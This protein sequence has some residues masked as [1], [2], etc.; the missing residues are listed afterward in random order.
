M[1]EVVQHCPLCGGAEHA[2][3]DQREFKGAVVS[4]RIC[5]HCGLVF[6]SPRMTEAELADFYRAQYRNLYQGQ[7]EPSSQ[8]LAVQRGR[9]ESLTGFA[10]THLATVD[11]HLD[12]GC[13]AGL[14]LRRFQEIF[15]SH[16]VGVEP[17]QAHRRYARA[18]GLTVYADLKELQA[19]NDSPFDLISM[20]HVLEHLPQPVSY[21]QDLRRNLL[22][23]QG[24]LLIEVPNLYAHDSFEVAHLTALS[25]HTLRQ[26]LAQAGFET[27]ALHK[28][29]APRSDLIPLYLTVLARPRKAQGHLSVRPERWVPSKRRLGMFWRRVLAR[30]A[31]RRA[32]LPQVG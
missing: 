1:T 10:Q 25:P 18:Q 11:R 8:D 23:P 22:T 5:R 29:G 17:A 20:A 21:L 26:V 7:T 30:L 14:L 13:S 27:I 16:P 9:A 24:A 6:Q 12:I 2:L 31:P 28:H 15:A 4:N 3:F 19:H 32:W